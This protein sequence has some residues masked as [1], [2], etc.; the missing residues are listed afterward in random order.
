MVGDFDR[1]SD[2]GESVVLDLSTVLRTVPLPFQ[3]RT[4]DIVSP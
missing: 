2:K 1:L 3:G 4:I